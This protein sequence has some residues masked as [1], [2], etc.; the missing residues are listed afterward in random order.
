[1]KVQIGK[2]FNIV[3]MMGNLLAVYH[4]YG[5]N[6]SVVFTAVFVPYLLWKNKKVPC[7][8]LAAPVLL[9]LLF[10][11][12]WAALAG[13]NALGVLQG[14]YFV[15]FVAFFLQR[16]IRMDGLYIAYRFFVLVATAVLFLQVVGIRVFHKYI[17][18][19]IPWFDTV[20]KE[21]A[22]Y[23][24]AYDASFLLIQ[25][26]RSVFTEPAGY[27]IY[28][29]MFL[30]VT[31]VLLP[32]EKT[33]GDARGGT[34]LLKRD[35]K[36]YAKA[37]I[38]KDMARYLLCGILTLGLFLSGS[39]TGILLAA[40]SWAWYFWRK[41]RRGRLYPI[42]LFV[43][44]LGAG[45]LLYYMQTSLAKRFLFRTF[46][47]KSGGTMG[48]VGG[49]IYGFDL[50]NY[51]WMQVLFGH[52]VV[53]LPGTMPFLS[54]W[55]RLMYYFGALGVLVYLLTVVAV[56]VKSCKRQRILLFYMLLY[57]VFTMT[58]YSIDLLFWGTLYFA[59]A[60]QM[61]GKPAGEKRELYGKPAG[62][63]R[64]PC[65]EHTGEKREPRGEPA[66]EKREPCGESAGEKWKEGER[67]GNE[68]G[69]AVDPILRA[70][71]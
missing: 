54:T 33:K 9:L 6:A 62:E 49:F 48:R 61:C 68:Q 29:G 52:G 5:V 38:D 28:V 16:E 26:P 41:F 57:S 60:D 43:V 3:C 4:I 15:V 1:M 13:R 2:L 45:L 34:A 55:P 53:S 39:S 66:G 65:G 37:W 70:F 20:Q 51:T 12:F 19:T 40:L 42:D 47:A 11:L 14:L 59:L 64:E 35:T 18:G 50:G 63:K 30:A 8:Y 56:F 58:L 17:L 24:S 67:F 69:G 31:L 46:L 25:R 7:R 71:S 21:F 32:Q 10:H 44:A 36:K 27:G 23:I 22:E